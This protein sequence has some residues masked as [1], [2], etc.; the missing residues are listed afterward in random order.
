MSVIISI[1]VAAIFALWGYHKKLYPTWAFVFNVVVAAY[2]GLMITP[3]VFDWKPIGG[4]LA[5]LGP[6]AKVLLM[7]IVTALYL[8]VSQLLSTF[9]LTTT[10]CVSFPKLFDDF[11]GM[12]L[13]F[14]GGYVIASI[15][16]FLLAA[17]PLKNDSLTS[18]FIPDNS[19]K[20]VIK[21][22]RFVSSISLQLGDENIDKAAGLLK[23]L[24]VTKSTPPRVVA[25]PNSVK[26]QTPADQQPQIQS[27]R[28]QEV[29][30]FN[31]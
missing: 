3:A 4:L 20:A 15:V 16:L 1:I 2:L 31:Q 24:P 21:A 28:K 30:D 7:F 13:G 22:C 9:Y 12:L 29:F 25:E 10:Y 17:S 11:G 27:P 6:Y 23:I 5:I 26:T 18:K 8:V 14:F 19:G